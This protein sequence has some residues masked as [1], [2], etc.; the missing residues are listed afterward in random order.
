MSGSVFRVGRLRGGGQPWAAGRGSHWG[1]G[2]GGCRLQP[3]SPNQQ[4]LLQATNTSPQ[5]V[6]LSWVFLPGAAWRK[7]WG[8]E[9]GG[10]LPCFSSDSHFHRPGACGYQER[11]L[12]L[13]NLGHGLCTLPR[14]S[15]LLGTALTFTLLFW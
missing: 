13:L 1:W 12:R 2:G 7:R 6:F 4:I 5:C 3:L 9:G 11:R 14:I 8:R 10:V 15:P